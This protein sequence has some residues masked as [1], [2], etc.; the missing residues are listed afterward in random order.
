MFSRKQKTARAQGGMAFV[1]P[2]PAPDP[3]SPFRFDS[4]AVFP[5][6]HPYYQGYIAWYNLEQGGLV[7]VVTPFAQAERALRFR[8]TDLPFESWVQVQDGQRPVPL[9]LY[10]DAAGPAGRW[11]K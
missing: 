8:L 11:L 7:T 6:S 5:Y 3:L 4:Q 9:A 1:Q 10:V 2:Q